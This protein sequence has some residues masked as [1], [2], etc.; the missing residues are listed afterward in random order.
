MID[1]KQLNNFINECKN[2]GKSHDVTIIG[3][4]DSIKE[5]SG[6][7]TNTKFEVVEENE[8]LQS[9]VIYIVPKREDKPVQMKVGD[10]VYDSRRY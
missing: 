6:F 9:D 7:I 5:L 10:K 8:L 3:S 2:I 4:K 1:I